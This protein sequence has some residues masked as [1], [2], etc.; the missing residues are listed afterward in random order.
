[1]SRLGEELVD[2]DARLE[3]DGLRLV[4]EWHRLKVAINFGC[5]QCEHANAEAE[6]SL[7]TS[8]EASARALEEAREADDCHAVAEERRRELQALNA[9]L[10][11]QVEACRAAL[12]SMKGAPSDEEEISRREEALLLEATKRSL[13][14][15]RLEMTERQVAQAEDAVGVREAKAQEEVDRR[16]AEARAD[17]V[18]SAAELASARAELLSLQQ[19]VASVES[20]A[21]QSMEEALRRQTLERVHAAMLK[22]SG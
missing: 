13:E 16:V 3:A 5:L 18:G 8:R 20:F 22:A 4:E 12:A 19:R 14:L 9:S 6:A 10:E 7:A 1:M 17:L 11:Q 21:Q 15:E 2:V